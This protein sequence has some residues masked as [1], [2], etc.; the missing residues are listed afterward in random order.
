MSLLLTP[1]HSGFST[2]EFTIDCSQAY[3]RDY[4]NV[5]TRDTVIYKM[6]GRQFSQA[7]IWRKQR[8]IFLGSSGICDP[9]CSTLHIHKVHSKIERWNRWQSFHIKATSHILSAYTSRNFTVVVLYWTIIYCW[10]V[11]IYA[12]VTIVFFSA[13]VS[14][15]CR[16]INEIHNI[17]CV[18]IKVSINLMYFDKFLLMLNFN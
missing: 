8:S 14:L 13:A 15:F 4:R 10:W 2:P 16:E 7:H 3:G 12:L 18:P 5:P 6:Y 17:F 9:W 11:T 1:P